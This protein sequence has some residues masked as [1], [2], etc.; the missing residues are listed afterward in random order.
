MLNTNPF[1]ILAE[2]ISPLTM[3]G[4]VVAMI[5]LIAL[6]TIIQILHIFLI[7]QKKQNCLLPK[8]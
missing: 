8:N 4:F 6:G 1:S 3:Q 7:T 2:T 5:I